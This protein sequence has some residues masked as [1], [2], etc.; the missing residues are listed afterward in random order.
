MKHKLELVTANHSLRSTGKPR[1]PAIPNMQGNQTGKLDSDRRLLLQQQ[2]GRCTFPSC[3]IIIEFQIRFQMQLVPT[4]FPEAKTFV[5]I[6][7][8]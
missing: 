8:M 1:P 2:L 5:F 3:K 4:Y 6:A 7:C